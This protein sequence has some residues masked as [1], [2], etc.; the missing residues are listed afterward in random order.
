MAIET[1]QEG[2]SEVEWETL[3]GS[4]K[5]NILIDWVVGFK[6]RKL[7]RRFQKF[8][9]TIEICLEGAEKNNSY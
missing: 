4:K 6:H 7:R 2:T 8:E 9:W 5:K 1:G 3:G